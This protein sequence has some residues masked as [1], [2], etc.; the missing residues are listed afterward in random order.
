MTHL[1][2]NAVDHGLEAAEQR[3]AR[4]KPSIGI[5]TVAAREERGALI[6][7]VMDDG[8]GIDA[9]AVS[10]RGVQLGLVSAEQ[11]AAAGLDLV[12]TAGFSTAGRVTEVSGRGVGLDVVRATVESLQGTVT[13]RTTPGIGTTF[14]MTLPLTLATTR[15]LVLRAGEQT[16]ALPLGMVSRVVRVGEGDLGPDAP[17]AMADLAAVLG[18]SHLP[19][20]GSFRLAV[21]SA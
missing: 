4:G 1:V 21:I 8:G 19:D 6:L 3:T 14:T 9:E 11:A 15:C 13:L 20:P 7:E 2:R 12:F 18:L 17:V 5:V 10:R 16:L